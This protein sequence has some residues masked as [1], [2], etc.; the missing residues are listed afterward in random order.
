[1]CMCDAEILLKMMRKITLS[2]RC[3]QKFSTFDMCKCGAVVECEARDLGTLVRAPP[4]FLP[5]STDDA[6]LT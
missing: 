5:F 1:M 2:V 3:S 4:V 6:P